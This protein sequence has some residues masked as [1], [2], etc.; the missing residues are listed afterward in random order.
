MTARSRLPLCP[1]PL[2]GSVCAKKS[3]VQAG[4][5]HAFTHDALLRRAALEVQVQARL[6]ACLLNFMHPAAA[7]QYSY[8]LHQASVVDVGGGRGRRALPA[9]LEPSWAANDG[10]S[11]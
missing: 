6:L 11:Q 2:E 9:Q 7:L 4:T 3:D 5:N 8:P 1:V 10:H